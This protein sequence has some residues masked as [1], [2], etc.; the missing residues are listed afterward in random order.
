MVVKRLKT[1]RGAKLREPSP[2]TT[3]RF[4]NIRIQVT[5]WFI[6][7][8]LSEIETRPIQ[9]DTT[10]NNNTGKG[11]VRQYAADQRRID[12]NSNTSPLAALWK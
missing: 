6:K 4:V 11:V 9:Q 5:T 10:C 8:E 12:G 3:Y 7:P 2:S 1:V